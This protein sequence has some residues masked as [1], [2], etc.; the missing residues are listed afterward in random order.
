MPI[1]GSFDLNDMDYEWHNSQGIVVGTD[2]TLNITDLVADSLTPIVFPANFSLTVVSQ[3]GCSNTGIKTVDGIFCNIQKGISANNDNLNDVF[4][5][6]GLG[7]KE[8][9]IFNR[10]GT[11]VYSRR[12][13]TNEWSG[14]SNSGQELPDATYYYVIAKDNGETITGWIYINRSN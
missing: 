5:L 11:E 6:S 12:N 9:T 1:A 8:L 10:Y 2:S 7:V 4:D 3:S 13:Y 14:L